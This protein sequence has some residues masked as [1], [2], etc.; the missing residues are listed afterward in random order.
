MLLVS[1]LTMGVGNV[2]R[3]LCSALLMNKM[4]VM[5]CSLLGLAHQYSVDVPKEL[6]GVGG[7]FVD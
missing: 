1:C 7:C 4:H 2:L 3:S 5:T 6:V